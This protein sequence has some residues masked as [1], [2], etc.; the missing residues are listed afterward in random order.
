MRQFDRSQE[1]VLELAPGQHAQVLG[2]PGSGKTASLIE[3]YARLREQQGWSETQVMVLTPGRLAASAL[4]AKIEQRLKGA[5][6]GTPVRTPASFAFSLL[7]REAAVRGGA[8][9]RLLTGAIQDEALQRALEE[10]SS[11]ASA[12]AFMPEV[13]ASERFRAELREIW[14]VIDESDLAEHH[15]RAMLREAVLRDASEP[16]GQSPAAELVTRW[17]FASH[18][19]ERARAL[20]A[21]EHPGEHTASGLLRAAVDLLAREKREVAVPALLIIDDAQDLGEGQLAL[22]AACAQHGSTV[23][24]FGDPD[25]ASGAFQGDRVALLTRL[26]AELERRGVRPHPAVPA[27]QSIT[28]E[29]VYRQGPRVRGAIQQLSSRIGAAGAGGQ[30]MATSE[31]TPGAGRDAV[32]FVR[33]HS[34]AEQIG[35]IAYRM[36]AL[37]LGLED[38]EAPLPWGEMALVCRSRGEVNRAVRALAAHQIPVGV[39]AGGAVLREHRI[40]R[41]LI[42]LLQHA[43]GYAELQV[44][45]ITELL[46]GIVGGLD[47]VA[48]RRLR[49]AV[50][51]QE[52]RVALETGAPPRTT[53]QVLSEAFLDPQTAPV[54]ETAGGR[55]LRRL[56][57][58]TLRARVA[59]KNGATAREVLWELWEGALLADRLQE[60]ALGANG[61]RADAA[62]RSLDAVMSLFFALQR[63]EE[64]AS[65]QP[66][67][68]LLH[69][70]L[71]R[72][73][74]EDTLARRSQRDEVTIAT[75]Q[76]VSGREFSCVM[77]LGPQEG[78]WPN[79]RAQGSLLQATALERWLRGGAAQ[80]AERRETLHDELRLFH[81]ACSRAREELLVV[82]VDNEDLAP[83]PFFVLGRQYEVEPLPSARLTL[84]GSVGEMR[85]RLVGDPGDDVARDSLVA[86]S[87]AQVPGAHP[88]DWYGILPP[89]TNE[90][91]VDLDAD[92]SARVTVSPSQLERAEACPLNWVI[93]TLGGSPGSVEASLG[94]LLH[95]AIETSPKGTTEEIMG[96]VNKAWP[97]LRFEAEW[98]EARMRAVMT[99]MVEGLVSYQ[100]DCEA[101]GRTLLAREASFEVAIGRAILRGTADRVECATGVSGAS[102]VSVLDLKTGKKLPSPAE[103]LAHAQLQAYQLGV[104]SGAFAMKEAAA[105]RVT[106]SSPPTN[107]GARLLYVHPQATNGKPYVERAQ[108]PLDAAQVGELSERIRQIADVMAASH[109]EARIEHHCNNEYQRGSCQLHI[110]PSVGRS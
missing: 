93:A 10:C 60:E 89:S 47:A 33:A 8:A 56:A 36:R 11:D 15:L 32:R 71:L 64:Q 107:A 48:V 72:D 83:G 20:L 5:I 45:Q 99:A 4:R 80:S 103:T 67:A 65:Q 70:L 79:L 21:T 6:A 9:P 75:P 39:S 101:S 14:R 63:H 105:G 51:L 18:R 82:S 73:V 22:L 104:I 84:R 30:R 25:L 87:R 68:S 52:R 108:P 35:M 77:V 78:V 29:R 110:I 17:E 31:L 57:V 41:E 81:R 59:H 49:R 66:V 88:D 2:A 95:Y 86:L 85:R 92:P 46:G 76:A 90:P 13:L 42:T 53:D 58:T 98:E 69:E 28:L 19:I 7:S 23:W 50:L 74:P 102:E 44:H 34:V 109:F 94:T 62:N 38:G 97:R 54:V 100:R 1:R 43:L 16:H 61:P 40:V 55:A 24:A 106:N 37:H 96:I 27:V 3:R 26:T 91:L 12:L